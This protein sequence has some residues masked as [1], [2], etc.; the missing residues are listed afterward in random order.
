MTKGQI[1]KHD[2]TKGSLTLYDS[3]G[4]VTYCEDSTGSWIKREY[5]SNSNV[6]YFVNSDGY[7]RK[8]EFDTNGN[9]IYYENSQGFVRHS[10]C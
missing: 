3:N 8:Y 6:T 9:E 10:I 7:W 5:D 4:K 1:L 2:F